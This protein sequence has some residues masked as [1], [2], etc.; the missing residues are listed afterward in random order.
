MTQALALAGMLRQRSHAVVGAVVGA[1]RQRGLPDFFRLGLGAPVETVES[2]TFV[3]SADGKI[4]PAATLLRAVRCAGRYGPNLDRIARVIDQTEPDVV[5]NFYEGL[6]GAYSL[7]R[8]SDVPVVAVGHQFMMGHPAYPA[9]PG[10]PL[11]RAAVEAYTRLVG[12]GAVAR[13]ALSFYDAEDQPARVVRVVPPL[14]R[15]GLFSLVGRP[16]DEA[17]LVRLSAQL[18]QAQPWIDRLPPVHA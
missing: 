8:V 4:R 1:S 9:Q 16:C 3:A 5:V 7:L 17:T 15:S 12:S 14:L 6:M 11:Q 13:L 2:P 10:Q 18:E